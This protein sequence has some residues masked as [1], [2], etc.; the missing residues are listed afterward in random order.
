M[1][2]EEFFSAIS[3]PPLASNTAVAKDVGVYAHVLRPNYSIQATFKKSSTTPHGLA[4][5]DT[6]VFAAQHDKAAIHVYSRLRG[7]QEAFVPL[8]ERVRCVALAGDVLVVGT[9]D[10]RI[11]L[12]EVRRQATIGGRL[13]D[14]GDPAFRS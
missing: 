8:S 1:L 10:G 12:W 6:H 7:N 13:T 11:L 14:P 2:V 9:A 4:A 5:S 3:G